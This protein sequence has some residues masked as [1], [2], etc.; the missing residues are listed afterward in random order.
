MSISGCTPVVGAITNRV[1]LAPFV[2]DL[3]DL[4]R[5]FDYLLDLDCRVD[6]DSTCNSVVT[7]AVDLQLV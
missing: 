4:H 6:V 1:V 3:L 7:R 5:Y 2:A